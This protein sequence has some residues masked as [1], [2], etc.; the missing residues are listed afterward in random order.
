M[1][2]H[3]L[4][5]SMVIPVFNEENCITGV[6]TNVIRALEQYKL[7]SAEII[8]VDDGSTD[9][10]PLILDALAALD[11]RV[12]ILRH[13][14]NKGLG[15]ANR[16]GF[17]EA[18]GAWIGWIPGDGQFEPHDVI[19]IFLR[20]H[21]RSDMITTTVHSSKRIKADSFLRVFLSKGLRLMSRLIIGMDGE[22]TGIFIF[23]K[24]IFSG[25]LPPLSTGYFN[26]LLPMSAQKRGNRIVNENI[27]VHPRVAGRSKVANLKTILHTIKD[28]ILV[29]RMKRQLFQ[30]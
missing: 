1:T 6:V 7:S 24:S 9:G 30:Q 17:Q 13:Q 16:T 11:R 25:G 3:S 15:M 8:L 5:F 19:E 23:R 22:T 21:D 20:H 28:M 29:R 27:P 12:R 26:L 18:R 10:T 14:I 2:T 4:Q